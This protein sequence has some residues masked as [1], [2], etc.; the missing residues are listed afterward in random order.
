MHHI[1]KYV[2]IVG[3]EPT[4]QLEGLKELIIMLHERGYEVILFSWHDPKWIKNKLGYKLLSK[5]SYAVCGPYVENL[6][7]YDT[8]KDN[9]INNVIG[10]SNQIIFRVE[11]DTIELTKVAFLD[12]IVY[13]NNK[14]KFIRK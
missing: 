5:I 6:R 2:T 3:G 14:P 12:K 8:S 11:K 4:D 13:E 10:S 1:P 7:I 9:G